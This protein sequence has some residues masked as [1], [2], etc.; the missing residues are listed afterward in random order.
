VAFISLRS[1]CS[2]FFAIAMFLLL[3]KKDSSCSECATQEIEIVGFTPSHATAL[4]HIVSGLYV[5]TYLFNNVQPNLEPPSQRL[6]LTSSNSYILVPNHYIPKGTIIPTT[7][8]IS[9]DILLNTSDEAL[10]AMALTDSAKAAA[11][12]FIADRADLLH[13]RR[14]SLVIGQSYI[15]PKTNESYAHAPDWAYVPSKTSFEAVAVFAEVVHATRH[16]YLVQ[17]MVVN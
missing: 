17:I 4:S 13:R 6:D 14:H 12:E 2:S 5:P 15:W 7:R 9:A 16:M 1:R 10:L 8:R 3:T 11:A